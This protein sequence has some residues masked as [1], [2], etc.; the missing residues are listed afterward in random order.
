M[1][2]CC[3]GCKEVCESRGCKDVCESCECKDVC[4]S[5]GCKDV[6]ESQGVCV[7]EK[8]YTSLEVGYRCIQVSRRV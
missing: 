8:M 4:E 2:A 1:H 6:C 5:C 7:C 3:E